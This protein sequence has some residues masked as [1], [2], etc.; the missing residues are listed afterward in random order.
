MFV[1]PAFDGL[2]GTGG[3]T[4]GA[5]GGAT[6]SGAGTTT[7]TAG[8]S[9]T[10][11]STGD[12]AS[13]SGGGSTTGGTLELTGGASSSGSSGSTGGE[14][15]CEPTVQAYQMCSPLADTGLLVCDT[16]STWADAKAACEMMCGR[17]AVL[18]DDVTRLAVFAALRARMTA[19]DITE[20]VNLDMNGGQ[21]QSTRASYWLGAS[22]AGPDMDYV[23]LDGTILPGV[24]DMYG[25]GPND[26]DYSGLCLAIGVWGKAA[27]NGEY[28]DRICDTEPY[29]YLCDP[30]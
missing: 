17:L 11:G 25:W 9:A 12:G 18:H 13:G 24:K 26:P 7:T 1:N 27:D 23:W 19:D 29:R 2:S 28:F 14:P 3:G 15:F 22:A 20:E 6:T 4:S 8:G 16:V 21:P 10:T 30:G 5:T